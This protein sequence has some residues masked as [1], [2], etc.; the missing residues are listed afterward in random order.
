VETVF[1]AVCNGL[2][3]KES[4]GKS[5]WH[6]VYAN[7]NSQS[8]SSFETGYAVKTGYFASGLFFGQKKLASDE[9]VP[10]EVVT[11]ILDSCYNAFMEHDVMS[12]FIRRWK[13]ELKTQLAGRNLF[14]PVVLGGCGHRRPQDLLNTRVRGTDTIVIHRTPYKVKV[15]DS[16]QEVASE[17]YWA[18]PRIWL[19]PP[20]RL[21]KAD[22]QPVRECFDTRGVPTFW[23]MTWLDTNLS[24]SLGDMTRADREVLEDVK[25]NSNLRIPKVSK[26]LMLFRAVR[27]TYARQCWHTWRLIRCGI[28]NTSLYRLRKDARNLVVD[29][30][31]RHFDSNVLLPPRSAHL[32]HM[33]SDYPVPFTWRLSELGYGCAVIKDWKER[34]FR[35]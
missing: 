17:L 2:Q 16:Q 33:F 25:L 6:P 5:Y 4:I 18:D 35:P 34:R 32:A 8:Y 28:Y 29:D 1:W 3:F 11:T 7:I 13:G 23:D 30:L 22:E 15:T 14:V 12:T 9:F 27:S 19:R 31:F 24:V 21:P 20:V 10:S 26:D